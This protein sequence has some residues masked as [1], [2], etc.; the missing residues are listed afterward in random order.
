M[1][2]RQS[3]I[4]HRSCGQVKLSARKCAREPGLERCLR[5]GATRLA[6]GAGELGGSAQAAQSR[7]RTLQ[8]CR[9]RLPEQTQA[10][11]AE[12]EARERADPAKE[13]GTDEAPPPTDS[14]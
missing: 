7:S 11:V 10:E 4:T 12:R 8:H 14:R 9:D 13:A 2:A 3:S 1:V 5:A 6:R